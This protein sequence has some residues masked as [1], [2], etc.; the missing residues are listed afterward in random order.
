MDAYDLVLQALSLHHL[1][2]RKK[3]VKERQL[4]RRAMELDPGYAMPYALLADW[5]SLRFGQGWSASAGQKDA[6]EADRLA[7]AAIE[8]DP[9]N[10]R[11]LAIYGHQRSFMFRDYDRALVFLERAL[12][13]APSSAQAWCYSSPTLSYIGDGKA[14]IERAEHGLRLSPRDPIAFWYYSALALGHLTQGTYDDAARWSNRAHL[15]NPKYLANLRFLIVSL[16]RRLRSSV[17]GTWTWTLGF[18]SPRSPTA[19]HIVTLSGGDG[20]ERCC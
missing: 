7:A 16:T 17:E 13:A 18:A 14:A 3:F 2:D 15:E 5:Y 1:F 11:A 8:R 9:N 10:A 12:S 20:W 4:L 6:V 19:T